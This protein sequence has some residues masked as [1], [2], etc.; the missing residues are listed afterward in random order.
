ML[1]STIFRLAPIQHRANLKGV[2]NEKVVD[3]FNNFEDDL[4][5]IRDLYESQKVSAHTCKY[6]SHIRLYFPHFKHIFSMFFKMIFYSNQG[7]R[8]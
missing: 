5:H 6:T 8:S 7:R 1:I 2:I 4:L 3:I